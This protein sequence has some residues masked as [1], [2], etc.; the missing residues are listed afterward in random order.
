MDITRIGSP[1]SGKGRADWFTG[2][3][4]I[5]PLFDAPSPVRATRAPVVHRPQ[6]I[7]VAGPAV[8]P[9]RQEPRA[10]ER[11]AASSSHRIEIVSQPDRR[12]PSLDALQR[13][14]ADTI[15]RRA[16]SA[17]IDT[18]VRDARRLTPEP[19]T[20]RQPPNVQNRLPVHG[21]CTQFRRAWTRTAYPTAH[22]SRGCWRPSAGLGDD[23]PRAI[24]PA[25]G[26]ALKR[27]ARADTRPPRRFARSPPVASCI[28]SDPRTR[29]SRRRC[30][31]HRR[32][33]ARSQRFP[34]A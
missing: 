15:C 33:G 18:Q 5:D 8:V 19:S 28:R 11:P 9:Q 20:T 22:I 17:G 12:N 29:T 31:A 24:S 6:S 34:R 21:N 26:G 23:R 13:V 2:T 4:R 7:S 10:T 30:P 1:S 14:D 32:T 27:P 3:V 16:H 25:R